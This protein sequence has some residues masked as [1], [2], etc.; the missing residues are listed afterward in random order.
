M[1]LIQSP[2]LNTGL[3]AVSHGLPK[4]AS[5]GL[6]TNPEYIPYARAFLAHAIR[7]TRILDISITLLDL[8]EDSVHDMWHLFDILLFVLHIRRKAQIG[9]VFP[10]FQP[11]PVWLSGPFPLM[12]IVVQSAA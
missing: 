10:H 11:P 8:H 5:L 6:V 9:L 1:Y 4:L 2:P 12:S 7:S 3:D